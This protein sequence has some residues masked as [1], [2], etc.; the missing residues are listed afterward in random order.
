[1]RSVVSCWSGGSDTE[2]VKSDK[3]CSPCAQNAALSY[4]DAICHKIQN[5]GAKVD[6][7]GLLNEVKSGKRTIDSYLDTLA[8][9]APSA[10]E[11]NAFREL[12]K[13]MY[14]E[15]GL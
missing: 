15:G 4:G 14:D 9:K 3:K 10:R 6:C 8:K 11:K 2:F 12:K 1:M 7:H 13:I 5:G